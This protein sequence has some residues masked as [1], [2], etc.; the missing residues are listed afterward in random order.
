[1]DATPEMGFSVKFFPGTWPSS[2]RLIA[3]F[4][5]FTFFCSTV[6]SDV[7]AVE[8]YRESV[9]RLECPHSSRQITWKKL[10]PRHRSIV[11]SSTGNARLQTVGALL[12]ISPVS[13]DDAGHY[14]CKGSSGAAT[15]FVV[16]V[17]E[18]R[19]EVVSDS[20]K[21]IV[22]QDETTLTCT[23]Y[24]NDA[25]FTWNVHG[26][27]RHIVS[28]D[29]F[30]NHVVVVELRKRYVYSLRITNVRLDDAGKYVCTAH[31][32]DDV[33]L[34]REISLHV[35][36]PPRINRS[37]ENTL[38]V[39]IGSDLNLFCNI[40]TSKE[41]YYVK[42][43]KDGKSVLDSTSS[44]LADRFPL[45]IENAMAE[46]SGNYTCY[47]ENKFGSDQVTFDVHVAGAP[48]EPRNVSIQ[49]DCF[50]DGDG[51]LVVAWLAPN[52]HPNYFS[53][54]RYVVNIMSYNVSASNREACQ[55]DT[56][57]VNATSLW[58]EFRREC[59][60][61]VVYMAEVQSVFTAANLRSR[62]TRAT[63]ASKTQNFSTTTL[64]NWLLSVDGPFVQLVLYQPRLTCCRQKRGTSLSDLVTML[65]SRLRLRI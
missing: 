16:T 56:F 4:F 42:W 18:P 65:K 43:L 29:R 17:L 47:A 27:E 21:A 48:M 24:G 28:H 40:S 35:G 52:V 39:E 3:S 58:Q 33:K 31:L 2:V 15:T 5:I 9:A 49:F 60:A 64:R 55:L 46:S 32:Y 10:L 62:F 41:F 1:M 11:L 7:V 6:C 63:N 26:N 54:D 25:Y 51:E 53:P 50:H 22:G 38:S 12:L 34:S 19:L 23:L 45:L 20:V 44:P 36:R 14:V 61:H 30:T 59:R 13:I 57:S 37:Y 8:V